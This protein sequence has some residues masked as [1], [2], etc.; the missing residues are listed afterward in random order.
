MAEIVEAQGSGRAGELAEIGLAFL[1]GTGSCG[2]LQLA[3]GWAADRAGEIA[4][5]SAPTGH[6]Q[7]GIGITQAFRVRED[8]PPW[9]RLASKQE[10]RALP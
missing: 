10:L 7:R 2:L 1:A 4:P 8:I 3:A 5:G 6:R 9:L